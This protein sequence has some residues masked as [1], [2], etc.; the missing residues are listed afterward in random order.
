MIMN[1]V[2]HF[3]RMKKKRYKFYKYKKLGY[4]ERYF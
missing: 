1:H 2:K 3:Y 4:Y